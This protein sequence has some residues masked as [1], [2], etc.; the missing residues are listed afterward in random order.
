MAATFSG[1]PSNFNVGSMQVVHLADS[2][3]TATTVT[4]TKADPVVMT[5]ITHGL[6][7]IGTQIRVRV[8][9]CT[10][11]TELNNRTFLAT[12]VDADSINLLN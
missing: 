11:Q 1:A 6:G 9:G 2:A 8:T 12:I 4:A 7:T 3:T 5:K 10:E